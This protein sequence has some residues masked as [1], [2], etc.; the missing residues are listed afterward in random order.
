MKKNRL[1]GILITLMVTPLGLFGQLKIGFID[2]NTIL[3]QSAEVRDVQAQLEKEQLRLEAQLDTFTER[4]D[5]LQQEYERQR[6]VL[7]TERLR[8]KELEIQ[9]LYQTALAFQ[10][11]K[12]GSDG[13][14]IRYQAQL[15][16][17]I[18]DKIDAA[19]KKIGAEGSY[20]YI[21]DAAGGALVYA[22]PA[23]D[24][25]ND[26]ITELRRTTSSD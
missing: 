8:E 2:S 13:E 3:Q 10:E 24:L 19:V 5:S 11:E 17:P 22:L 6:L 1:N 26:V 7:S 23:H 16:S 12:F 4:L 14:L 15:M 9:D 21:M 25:T 20:D 18:L